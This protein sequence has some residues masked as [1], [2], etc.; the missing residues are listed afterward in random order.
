MA[1]YDVNTA[2]FGRFRSFSVVF[3]IHKSMAINRLP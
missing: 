3:L 1:V 2:I